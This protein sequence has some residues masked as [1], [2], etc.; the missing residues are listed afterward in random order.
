MQ[1][2]YLKVNYLLFKIM[3]IVWP[4]LSIHL[5]YKKMITLAAYITA[6]IKVKQQCFIKNVCRMFDTYMFL[7]ILG[8]SLVLA[9]FDYSD[10]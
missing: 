6:E 3:W 8:N 7:S 4:E 9:T 5:R 1:A 2:K 10:D